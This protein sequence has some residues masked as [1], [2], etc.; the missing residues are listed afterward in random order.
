MTKNEI[1]AD[2]ILFQRACDKW[3]YRNIG[4]CVSNL[5][6][7][8]GQNLEECAK[9]FDFDYD[10]AMHWFQ[11]EDWEEPVSELIRRNADF[12]DLE[13][14]AD[15]VDSWADV[16]EEA[17]VSI[18][19]WERTKEALEEEIAALDDAVSEAEDELHEALGT[20]EDAVS[21][22]ESKVASLNK[23]RDDAQAKFDE[24]DA[25]EDYVKKL[26]KE[27][28][29]REVI[30]MKVTGDSYEEIGRDYGLEPDYYEVY[31]HWT[32]PEGWTASDLRDQGEVVFDFGGLRIWG[33]RTTGQS[34]SMDY[35]IRKI[36]KELDEN[37]WIWG[38]TQ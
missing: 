20:A 22:I 30:W 29:L 25:F 19:E 8:V 4:E 27:E 3:V 7:D 26:D 21:E 9:I 18:S 37:H 16:C 2:E 1:I 10:D 15:E 35:V 23:A 24:I 5:M 28:D 32:I 34:I 31:E 17:G 12:D 38:D 33:R 13:R 11:V 36:V 14:I 6:Y